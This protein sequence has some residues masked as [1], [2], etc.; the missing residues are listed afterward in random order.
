MVKV[1]FALLL[2]VSAALAWRFLP[3]LRARMPDDFQTLSGPERV[4]RA[5]IQSEAAIREKYRAAGV[6]YPGEIFIRWFKREAELEIWARHG[7]HA[8]QLV[9]RY[10]ILKSSGGPGPKRRD[11]DRQVPEGVYR[12]D[13]FNPQSLYHLSLGLNY[14]NAADRV[15]SDPK[16]PGGDIFI[17]GKDVTIGCA[18]LGDPGIEEVYLAA[19][20]ARDAGQAPIAVHIFP[21][22]MHG[23][24]WAEF[25]AAEPARRP[26]L[27]DFWAQ[28]QPIYAAFEQRRVVPAITITREGRY[29]LDAR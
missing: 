9:A 27:T 28:L 19:L 4:A 24:A 29:Q 3:S 26:E 8:F 13:R 7:E 15:L 22:R 23:P 16:K 18:P 6:P 14:P 2:L 20:D 10:P 11:G 17:H 5:R 12:I 1:I 21:A 25:A